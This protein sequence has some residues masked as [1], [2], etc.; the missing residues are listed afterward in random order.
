MENAASQSEFCFKIR[1]DLI[2]LFCSMTCCMLL[3]KL[4][5]EAATCSRV[6]QYDQFFKV[7][8]VLIIDIWILLGDTIFHSVLF[9]NPR[10]KLQRARLRIKWKSV[11]HI[12]VKI[13]LAPT[14]C[15]NGH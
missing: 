11:T 2:K 1:I 14:F 7:P 12:V 6:T 3:K 8:R 5:I 10:T 9:V 15:M 4:A 13:G